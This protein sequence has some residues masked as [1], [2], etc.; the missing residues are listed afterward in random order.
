[1]FDKVLPEMVSVCPPR[2]PKLL[3]FELEQLRDHIYY[4]NVPISIVNVVSDLLQHW[5]S[6]WPHRNHVWENLAK[7]VFGLKIRNNAHI[8]T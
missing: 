4:T 2:I 7:N 1:M 6:G 3:C 5:D 8:M